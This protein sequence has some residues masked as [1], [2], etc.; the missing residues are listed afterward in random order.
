MRPIS[1]TGVVLSIGTIASALA[2]PLEPWRLPEP[3]GLVNASNVLCA[4]QARSALL[5]WQHRSTGRTREE[6]L[7]LL[8]QSPKALTLRLTSAMRESVEDA[9]AYPDLSQY[10]LYFFRS[11]VCF[12]ET[13]AAVRMPRLAVGLAPVRDC[14]RTHGSEKSVALSN[15]LQGVVRAVEP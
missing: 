11:E 8:P 4:E 10:T 1:L 12:R 13:L 2:Q 9:F 7:A 14:Q 15:C 6:V 5:A 3:E